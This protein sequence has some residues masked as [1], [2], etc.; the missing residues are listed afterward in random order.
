M[1]TTLLDYVSSI[2]RRVTADK[3]MRGIEPAAVTYNDVLAEARDDILDCMRALALSDDFEG[4]IT[5]NHVPMLIPRHP[6]KPSD[7]TPLPAR[8][9]HHD[10]NI[11]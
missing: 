11:S 8:T 4:H 6:P 2:C 7:D 9:F 10:I 3:A 1:S 5:I